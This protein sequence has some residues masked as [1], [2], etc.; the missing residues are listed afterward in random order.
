MKMTKLIYPLAFALAITLASTG[1]HNRQV[2]VTPIP[3]SRTGQVGG[4]NGGGTLPPGGAF[5]PNAGGVG[6]GG[7]QTAEINPGDMIEDRPALA[8]YTIHFAFDSAAIKSSEQLNLESVAAALKL[9]ANT[10]LL[11]EGNCDERGTREYNLALGARRANAVRDYL[12]SRGVASSRIVT[13]SWG[14]ERPV[15]PGSNEDAWAR[16]RNGHTVIVEGAR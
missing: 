1:C 8:A 13:L 11:I 14:K 9:D 6:T 12:A 2:K 7:G 10:K 4:E 3:G 15:D 5:N 16:N